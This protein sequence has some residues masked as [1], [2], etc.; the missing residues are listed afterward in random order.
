MS[1]SNE[2][3]YWTVGYSETWQRWQVRR[4][5]LDD[6]RGYTLI[7]DL[8]NTIKAAA[9]EFDGNFS[10][11]TKSTHIDEITESLPWLFFITNDDRLCVRQIRSSNAVQLDTDVQIISVCRCF[12]S[13]QWNVDLGFTVAYLKADGTAWYQTREVSQT[14]YVWSGPIQISDAGSNNVGIQV[15]RLLDYRT[16][17]YVNGVNKLYISNRAYIGE[18]VKTE[19]VFADAAISFKTVPFR[20]VTED[21]TADFEIIDVSRYSDYVV[22]VVANYPIFDFDPRW[23]DITLD[24]TGT[25]HVEYMLWSEG[26][27]YIHMAE[28]IGDYQGL[29]FQCRELNRKGYYVSPQC[30]MTWPATSFTL[31][32]EPITPTEFVNCDT[33]L[34]VTLNIREKQIYQVEYTETVDC[35]TDVS[36]SITLLEMHTQDVAVPVETVYATVQTA[37]TLN[38]TQTGV[39]PV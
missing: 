29:R 35:D 16:G 14:G 13:V 37:V 25:Q 9:I 11:A 7:E 15:F 21:P 2:K 22:R 26:M 32:P 8:G 20:D 38:L 23:E 12:R 24:S 31:R 6:P 4:R 17:I 27:L 18:T 28:P 10:T 19:F 1:Y 34:A 33:Q 30:L 39:S 3:E 36:T 5:D